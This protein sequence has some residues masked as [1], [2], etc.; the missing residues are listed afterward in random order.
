MWMCAWPTRTKATVRLRFIQVE[1]D[2]NFD[3]NLKGQGNMSHIG[4]QVV[5]GYIDGGG[6][7]LSL[8]TVSSNICARKP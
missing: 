2:T 8:K 5:D 7:T 6:N 1:I 4:G 3:L